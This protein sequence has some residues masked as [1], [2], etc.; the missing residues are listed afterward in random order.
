M[1]MLGWSVNL[2]KLFLDR[3]RLPERLTSNSCTYLSPIIDD[4]P[5]CISGRGNESMWT[6]RVSNPGPLALDSDALRTAL[7]GPANRNS[8]DT[9]TRKI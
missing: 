4:C 9:I 5:S 2:T 6:D 1:V 3:H 8:A 7:R